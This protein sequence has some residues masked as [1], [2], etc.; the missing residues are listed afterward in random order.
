MLKTISRI[1]PILILAAP[2]A[3]DFSAGKD[4]DG[5]ASAALPASTGAVDSTA[6]T[7]PV[8]YTYQVVNTYLHDPGAFTQGLVF[9]DGELYEGTGL[10]GQSSLRQ[11]VL[12]TGEVT[13][14]HRV[15]DQFFGEGIAVFGDRIIQLTW[16]SHVGFVYD[17]QNFELLQQFTYP[18]EGWGLTHDGERLI[19]SDGTALLYFLDPE[20][21]APLGSVEV[22][23]QGPVAA[24]NELEYIDGQVYANIWGTDRIARIAPQTGKVMGWIDLQEL[25]LPED[26][27]QRVDVLNG[28]AYDSAQKRLFVTGKWWPK[29]FE[30]EL[31]PREN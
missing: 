20:T 9:V 5:H 16:R 15:P 31:I 3:C 26:R 13:R 7:G 18:T 21:F 29:L 8:F 27:R 24:L 1:L 4:G 17:R 28:I 10:N 22:R 25:L 2:P 14:I 30:I 12:E 11:V 19:M 6:A 23:D